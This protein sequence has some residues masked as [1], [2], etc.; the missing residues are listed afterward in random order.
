MRYFQAILSTQSGIQSQTL[1]AL[2]C[3]LYTPLLR[4]DKGV[5][6][7]LLTII[8]PE[9]YYLVVT[10]SFYIYSKKC[11]F[12]QSSG[13]YKLKYFLRKFLQCLFAFSTVITQLAWTNISD[14]TRLEFRG[15]L[16]DDLLQVQTSVQLISPG[17]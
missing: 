1:S 12:R 17:V 8:F 14:A 13:I 11:N 7:S 15:F 3:E 9:Q 10:G 6:K 16:G 5:A 4:L 2:L